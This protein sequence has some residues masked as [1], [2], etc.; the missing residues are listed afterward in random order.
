MLK[1]RLIAVGC[2][3]SHEQSAKHILDARH[4]MH[5]GPLKASCQELQWDSVHA[6]MRP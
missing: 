4:A 2:M 3:D 6:M 1:L 5:G